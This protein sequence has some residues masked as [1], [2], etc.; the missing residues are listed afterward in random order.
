MVDWHYIKPPHFWEIKL[1]QSSK[2]SLL[3]T[4]SKSDWKRCTAGQMRHAWC[5]MLGS[6]SYSGSEWTGEL[7][8][9]YSSQALMEKQ[10]LHDLWVLVSTNLSFCEQID[11]A[12]GSATRMAGLVLRTFRRRS[13]DLMITL[14]RS[15]VQLDYCSQLWSHRDQTNI[16][17][18]EAVQRQFLSHLPARLI[19]RSFHCWGLTPKNGSVRGIRSAFS[20]S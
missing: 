17:K 8:L 4:P 7:P 20:G 3:F 1:Y 10:C 19:G 13:R 2:P 11:K 6:L 12:V 15:L 5:L 16:N 18:I 14:L 9:T